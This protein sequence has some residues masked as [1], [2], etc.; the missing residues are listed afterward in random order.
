MVGGTVFR[1]LVLNCSPCCLSLTQ[2][3]SATSHSPAM[4]EGSDLITV[5]SSRCLGTLTRST[6]NPLSSLWKVMHSSRPEISSVMDL[7]SGI[8]AVISL[9]SYSLIILRKIL[10]F[11]Q[12][13]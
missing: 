7:C 13:A 12:A 3:P 1:L 8:A 5:V 4:A 11:P 10:M 9:A 6:Q 2:Q